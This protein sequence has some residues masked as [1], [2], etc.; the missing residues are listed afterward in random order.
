LFVYYFYLFILMT[1]NEIVF[2]ILM[3]VCLFDV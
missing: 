2:I 3:F 1:M